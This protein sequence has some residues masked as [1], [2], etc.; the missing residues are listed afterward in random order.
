MVSANPRDIGNLYRPRTQ[1]F[2]GGHNPREVLDLQIN[3]NEDD[4]GLSHNSR[5]TTEDKESREQ[6]DPKKRRDKALRELA[7]ALQHIS[8]KPETMDDVVTR[9]P[10]FDE[11][12]KLLESGLGVDLGAR[13]LSLAVG[14]NRGPARSDTPYVTYGRDNSLGAFGKEDLQKA[15]RKYRGRKIGRFCNCL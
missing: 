10:R 4:D 14:A 13:G 5:N 12:N 6:R 7:P 9:S 2:T 8:I 3:P 1:E 11:E 15:K